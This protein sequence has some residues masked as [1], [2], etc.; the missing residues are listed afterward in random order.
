MCANIR[1]ISDRKRPV[2][3]AV[4]QLT[5]AMTTVLVEFSVPK[6]FDV[7]YCLYALRY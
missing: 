4:T 6:D 7:T 5:R 2:V 3:R 1:F